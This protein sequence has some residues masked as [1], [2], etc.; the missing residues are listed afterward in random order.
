MSDATSP[1]RSGA[2]ATLSRTQAA[3]RD[4]IL[5]AAVDLATRHGYDGLEMRELA[6]A[7]GVSPATL[8]QYYGSKDEVLVGALV[9]SGVRTTEAV[10]RRS[11]S[12]DG[13]LDERL[14]AAFAR[15]VRAYETRPLLY[16]AM[17][18][19]DLAGPTSGDAAAGGSPWTGRSWLDQAVDDTVPGR[20]ALVEALEQLVLA[21]LVSLVTGTAPADV[22][23]RFRRSVALLCP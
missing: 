1:V 18:R 13:H 7:A 8:Y 12:S 2:A 19:A 5:D 14:V 20:D 17:F 15:V 3:T 9:E 23:A 4:R 10:G 22:T 6:A 21:G 11:A 16:A